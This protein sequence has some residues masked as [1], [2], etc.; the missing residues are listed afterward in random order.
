MVR[1]R[2][3]PHRIAVLCVLLT[4]T[5]LMVFGSS[6][7]AEARLL[8][9]PPKILS[10][11]FIATLR[12][13]VSV[14]MPFS[15]S[16]CKQLNRLLSHI[17][18][19][20]HV[21]PAAGGDIMSRTVVSVD[22]TPVIT[23]TQRTG[24]DTSSLHLSSLPDL[25]LTADGSTDPLSLLLGDTAISLEASHFTELSWLAD[26]ETLILT[27]PESIT[28]WTS[29]SSVKATVSGAGIARRKL[30]VKV[31]KGDAEAF[32]AV[33]RSACPAGELALFL[34]QVNCEGSQAMTYFYRED[35]ALLKV[36]YSGG[37]SI[38]GGP[39]RKISLNWTM[40]R[41]DS[42]TCDILTLKSP[43]ASGGDRDQ[44]SYTRNA[45]VTAD[46]H[47]SLKASYSRDHVLSKER[48]ITKGSAELQ[49]VTEA[50]GQRITG[51]VS[52]TVTHGDNASET[53]T[54]APDL[55]FCHDGSVS[56]AAGIT[57]ESA[58]RVLLSMTLFLKAEP[59]GEFLWPLTREKLVLTNL[60]ENDLTALRQTSR[61]AL[62]ADLIPRL[63][64]LD[65]ED[66]RFL[67]EDMT[68][69]AWQQVV[70]AARAMLQTK[71]ETP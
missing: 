44:I 3:T 64:L 8:N 48:T 7:S 14:M 56:G 41:D 32:L 57:Q 28:R 49:S 35:G 16:R 27:L 55:L 2:K 67:S 69:D 38:D 6:A 34:M 47:V 20:L 54:L 13:E 22:D 1:N 53:C 37:V 40:C 4:L 63:V 42:N 62:A 50:D 58:K 25:A 19:T 61:E 65:R 60:T 17:G 51:T 10:A 15:E 18:L 29:E 12:T 33:V 52:V 46:G 43:A 24:E 59:A 70:D 30:T 36:N 5:V 66:T 21:V 45:S 26:A 11:S 23:A 71:E 9:E 39:L 68:D 31:A